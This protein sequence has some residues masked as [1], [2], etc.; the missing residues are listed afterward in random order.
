MSIPL[1]YG[2]YTLEYP[3]R[4]LKED[5]LV[6]VVVVEQLSGLRLTEQS[7][8]LLSDAQRSRIYG[9]VR[10]FTD[11]MIDNGLVWPSVDGQNYLIVDGISRV[12][13]LE[14][15]ATRLADD[16]SPKSARHTELGW[17]Q[18]RETTDEFLEDLGY[19][20][21][22]KSIIKEMKSNVP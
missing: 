19:R 21:Q 20:S 16:S 11:V 5:R 2:G 12:V 8:S 4:E 9:E 1:C 22:F 14:F 3:D 17:R 10:H 13:A 15:S 6:N 18:Q 7:S